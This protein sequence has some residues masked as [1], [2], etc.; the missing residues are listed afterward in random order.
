MTEKDFIKALKA[1]DA[2]LRRLRRKPRKPKKRWW[3]EGDARNVTDKHTDK[4]RQ[5][6][7]RDPAFARELYKL[8]KD[9]FCWHVNKKTNFNDW[10]HLAI[11]VARARPKG[12][13]EYVFL[14]LEQVIWKG[15]A[16]ILKIERMIQ[17]IRKLKALPGSLPGP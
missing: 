16:E 4:F 8:P 9:F 6:N 17:K 3:E 5:L 15:M 10:M 13:M 11:V 2:F 12:A 14:E 7:E 1:R